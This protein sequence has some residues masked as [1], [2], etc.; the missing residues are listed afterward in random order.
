MWLSVFMSHE[1]DNIARITNMLSEHNILTKVIRRSQEPDFF[2]VF[3]T[4]AEFG[5]AQALIVDDEL[6]N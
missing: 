2:E 3:V 5:E 6:F 4:Q 1:K